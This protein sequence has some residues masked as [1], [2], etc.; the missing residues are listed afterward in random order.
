M[1]TM[2]EPT[3]RRLTRGIALRKRMRPPA[4]V[5]ALLGLG[6]DCTDGHKRLTRG[7]DFVLFG[8]SAETHA[9]MQETVVKVCE[10]L[11]QRGKRIIDA[12][13]N[14]LRELFVSVCHGE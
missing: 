9:Q 6:L 10:R 14:E 11:D 4:K 13:P 5:S 2:V 7:D 8:G 12:S 3:N 1:Q